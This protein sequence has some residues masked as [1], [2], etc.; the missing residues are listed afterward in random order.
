MAGT[1]PSLE[2]WRRAYGLAAEV[3]S[4]APWTWM[5]DTDHIGFE[6]PEG[7]TARFISIMGR[8]GEHLAIGVYRGSEDLFRIIDTMCDPGAVPDGVLEASQVQLS[9]EDR[10]FLLPEDRR[11]I[12]RLGLKFRGRNAWPCFRSYLPGQFPWSV[13]GDELR[14]LCVA[15]EQVLAVAPRFEGREDDLERL[16]RMGMEEHVFLVRTPVKAA[17]VVEWEESMVKIERPAPREIVPELSRSLLE[18]AAGFPA[19]DNKLEVELRSTQEP[20]QE[21]KGERP[22]FAWVMLVVEASSG[23]IVGQGLL[24]PVPTLDA[25]YAQAAQTFLEALANH[26]IRP[27]EVF[28]RTGRLAALFRHVCERLGTTLTVQPSLPRAEDAFTSLLQFWGSG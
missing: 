7:G 13:D 26:E 11:V 10:D 12:K 5:Y 1:R 25:V 27:S 21:R 15:L 8:L 17:G 16:N 6:D 9:F 3:R 19:V 2:Q 18:R 28:V 14:L 20:I 23:F 4:L 24:M 22:C